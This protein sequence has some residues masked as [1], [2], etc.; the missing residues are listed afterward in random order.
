MEYEYAN[1]TLFPIIGKLNSSVSSTNKFLKS[2]TADFILKNI[3][4]VNSIIDNVE[5][6]F[7]SVSQI[8]GNI[9]VELHFANLMSGRY[10]PNNVAS[11]ISH[12]NTCFV[13]SYKSINPLHISGY[14]TIY[15]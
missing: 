3:K 2:P 11:E 8:N 12:I 7:E 6:K 5:I 9:K 4:Y 15:S 10:M 14:F 1:D 13:I